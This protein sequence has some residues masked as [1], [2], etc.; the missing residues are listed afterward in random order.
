MKK[1]LLVIMFAGLSACAQNGPGENE[2]RS[3]LASLSNKKGCASARVLFKEFPVPKSRADRNEHIL[4]PFSNIGFLKENDGS[5]ELTEQGRAVYDAQEQG[6]CYTNQYVLSDIA[7]V[8]EESKDELPAVLSGAWYVS[9]KITPSNVDE[10]VKNPQIIQ[11]ASMASLEEITKTHSFT[12][13]M[14]KKRG[15]DQLIISDPHFIG[16]RPGIHFNMA[17]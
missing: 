10:W 5:Y 6:F 14:A 2:I 13:R 12:V 15:E 16:F 4:H 7:V 3:V 17:W 11:A 9:F 1:L 8:K